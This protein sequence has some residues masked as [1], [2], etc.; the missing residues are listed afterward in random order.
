MKIPKEILDGLK[1][2]VYPKVKTGGQ[3][4]GLNCGITLSHEDLGFSISIGHSKSQIKN[5]DFAMTVF[6]L[7]FHE[8]NK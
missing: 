1:K 7:W 3:T 2:E 6:E 4:V 5:L 8:I